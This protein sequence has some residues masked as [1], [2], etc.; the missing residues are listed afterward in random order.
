MQKP[1]SK[2]IYIAILDINICLSEGVGLYTGRL[3]HEYVR[4]V[5]HACTFIL[6]TIWLA[7]EIDPWGDLNYGV[8]LGS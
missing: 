6:S 2:G 3:I 1:W 5:S 4:Y 7:G 8:K